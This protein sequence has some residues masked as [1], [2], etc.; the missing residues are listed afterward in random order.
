MMADMK[1][2][3]NAFTPGQ[4]GLS[5]SDLNKVRDATPRLIKGGD[6]VA[7]TKFGDKVLFRQSGKPNPAKTTTAI[8]TVISEQSNYLTCDF[9]GG[10]VLVA[11]PES[12]RGSTDFYEADDEISVMRVPSASVAGAGGELIVWVI[13]GSGG[14]GD[15]D[16]F[17]KATTKAG[18]PAVASPALGWVTAGADENR[19]YW[20]YGDAETGVWYCLNF[21]EVE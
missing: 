19:M 20:R 7:S 11:K 21:L 15:S 18:L 12:Q 4:R 8:M 13:A 5:A 1:Q 9:K 2:K 16:C 3:P 6:G 17:Y 10:T 14:S